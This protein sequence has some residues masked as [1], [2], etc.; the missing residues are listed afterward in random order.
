MPRTVTSDLAEPIARILAG[1][2][3]AG[4]GG[5]DEQHSV[6]RAIVLPE[7]TLGHAYV[8]FYRRN[9]LTYPGDVLVEVPGFVDGHAAEERDPVRV[10]VVHRHL[11]RAEGELAGTGRLVARDHMGRRGVRAR[12]AVRRRLLGRRPPGHGGASPRRRARR[13]RRAPG[14]PRPVAG[15]AR[16]TQRS[17]REARGK[18]AG[19]LQ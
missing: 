7:G 5:T 12:P 6:L 16:R 2:I 19:G 18:H 1:S 17:T 10:G 8:D 4:D 14:G 11:E 15:A 9:H 3:D 13:L